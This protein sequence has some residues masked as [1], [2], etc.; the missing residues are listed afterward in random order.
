MSRYKNTPIIN[1][2]YGIWERP[3]FEKFLEYTYIVRDGDT[4][5][6]I[7]YEVYGREDWYYAI[8]VAN[9]IIHPFKDLKV[10]MELKIPD[11]EEILKFEGGLWNI[12]I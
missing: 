12:Q 9:N 4:L 2:V 7:S 3:K 5:D 6:L 8:A 1:G 10:G 11:P